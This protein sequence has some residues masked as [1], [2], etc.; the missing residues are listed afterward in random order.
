MAQAAQTEGLIRDVPLLAKLA[1]PDLKALASKG[2][3]RSFPPGSVIFQ[4][5]DRGDSLHV[6]IEGRVRISV[7]SSQGEEAT[8]AL[9]GP[10]EFVGD[11]ALLDGL[12][13]SA[14]AIAIGRTKTLVVRRDDFQRWLAERPKAA[15]ALLEA[16]SLR[17]RRTDEQLTDLT[18]LDL[19]SRLA[20]RLLTLPRDSG[21]PLV[22]RVTQ[23][24]L[25]AM[26][27]VSRESVNKQ[28][29][30]FER[31]GWVTLG[32]GRVTLQDQ[33]ALRSVS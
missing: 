25:G 28:L 10:G 8:V 3:V 20:K 4:E 15:F 11:L 13:R 31:R 9:L 22:V 30:D 1:G 18:F 32:R 21:K 6:V 24:E 23:A 33:E 16:L 14:S 29:N 27:G 19:A 7:G 12:P 17:V 2:R 5:G 26:L